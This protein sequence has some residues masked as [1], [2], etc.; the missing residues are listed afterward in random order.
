MIFEGIYVP[1]VTPF[2]ADSSID[3][4]AWGEVI[5]WQL[6]NGTHGI[7]VGGSTGEFF[8]LTQ[9]E[10]I[11]QFEFAK[12]RLKGRVP[13]IA[14]INDLLARPLLRVSGGGKGHRGRRPARRRTAVCAAEPERAGSALPQNRPHRQPPDNAL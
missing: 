12:A 8:S 11:S 2:R 5:D 1:L 9:E 13:L 14:G 4:D 3:Y 10:R 7:V 6:E